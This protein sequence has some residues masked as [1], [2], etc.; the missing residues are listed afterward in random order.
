MV[1]SLTVPLFPL[2]PLTHRYRDAEQRHG[3]GGAVVNTPSFQ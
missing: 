3:W 1:L 2:V